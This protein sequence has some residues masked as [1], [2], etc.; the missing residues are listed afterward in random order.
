[1]EGFACLKGFAQMADGCFTLAP[2]ND[3]K[4]RAFLERFTVSKAEMRTTGYGYDISADL[5][6]GATENIKGAGA[7]R[8]LPAG[9]NHMGLERSNPIEDALIGKP[10]CRCI[11]DPYFNT[12]LL[13]YS[14]NTGKA[15]VG[16][17]L[18]LLMIHRWLN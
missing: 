14:R 10:F 6:F 8:R 12:I 11:N 13:K 18:D 7:D 1:V 4:F 16:R 2:D 9:T 17:Q 5:F 15:K 3:I